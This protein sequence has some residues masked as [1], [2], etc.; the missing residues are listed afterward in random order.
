MKISVFNFLSHLYTT[1][2]YISE[3][4]IQ[5]Q[6]T[7]FCFINFFYCTATNAFKLKFVSLYLSW[8]GK[9]CIQEGTLAMIVNLPLDCRPVKRSELL[10]R[11]ASPPPP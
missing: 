4:L 10:L 6:S 8:I 7:S 5:P 9:Y 11:T 3:A 2:L 1:D